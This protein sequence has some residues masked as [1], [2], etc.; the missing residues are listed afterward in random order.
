MSTP[1]STADTPY[2]KGRFYIGPNGS[3]RFIGSASGVFLAEK[4]RQIIASST[5][6]PI[7]DVFVQRNETIEPAE[8]RSRVGDVASAGTIKGDYRNPVPFEAAAGAA[9]SPEYN[10]Q[11][12]DRY[13]DYTLSHEWFRSNADMVS[14][15]MDM[16]FEMWHPLFPF[17]DGQQVVEQLDRYAAAQTSI[18]GYQTTEQPE[19][20]LV[21]S[22][23]LHCIFCITQSDDLNSPNRPYPM[24]LPPPDAFILA[25]LIC[26]ALEEA[27]IGDLFAIQGLLCLQLYLWTE[28]KYRP[29]SHLGGMITKIALAHGLHRCP[30]RHTQIFPTSHERNMRKR[31]FFSIYT[32]E[33]LLAADFGIPLILSDTDIDV[34]DP[35]EE[36]VH[37]VSEHEFALG[38]RKREEGDTASFLPSSQSPEDYATSL[39]GSRPLDQPVDVHRDRPLPI[40]R[41]GPMSALTKVARMVGQAMEAF[42]KSR[43]HRSEPRGVIILKTALDKW[44]NELGIEFAEG[45]ES[46]DEDVRG[47]PYRYHT[48]FTCLRHFHKINLHRP[49]IALCSS[50]DPEE[51]NAALESSVNS[52]RTILAKLSKELEKLQGIVWW[53]AYVDM[54]FF[55]TL[56]LVF[57]IKRNPKGYARLKKD[58][59]KADKTIDRLAVRWP[60]AAS[61]FVRVIQHMTRTVASPPKPV[62]SSTSSEA[63]G[64]ST[65]LPM[66][67]DINFDINELFVNNGFDDLFSF[68]SG[69]PTSFAS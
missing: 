6:L 58:L 55:S 64:T 53:P 34:C 66:P 62:A 43:R 33:R 49:S 48:L 10:H 23:I 37:G 44:W 22:T 15:R 52:A 28:K 26:S 12:R 59:K 29:A 2:E 7:E 8:W 63:T 68:E 17:L 18:D 19:H 39:L 56:I 1:G 16:Y 4:L 13:T 35:T 25:S 42:N 45:D 20:D 51:H 27:K 24:I 21:L 36:E 3:P 57:A 5:S 47:I 61:P 32:L 30:F 69:W 50:S 14:T 40:Q 65:P 46:E 60:K 67:T 38:K 11:H 31:V 9:T 41:L 54:V